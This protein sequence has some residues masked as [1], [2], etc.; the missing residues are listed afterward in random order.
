MYPVVFAVTYTSE[1]V[2]TWPFIM[3]LL[4]KI[5]FENEFKIIV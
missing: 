3:T 2:E 4:S 1:E 5:K